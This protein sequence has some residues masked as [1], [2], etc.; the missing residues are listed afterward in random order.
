MLRDNF[1]VKFIVGVVSRNHGR[2]PVSHA[3]LR[4]LF[5]IRLAA[6][7]LDLAE[8]GFVLR[9]GMPLPFK[10]G[11]ECRFRGKVV[12]GFANIEGGV[13]GLLHQLRQGLHALR[14]RQPGRATPRTVFV[15]PKAKL[16]RSHN[17]R[18]TT[19]RAN[20]SRN[21]GPFEKR[22]FSCQLV[23]Y[24]RLPLVGLVAIAPNP[25]RGV[26]LNNPQD[27]RLVCSRREKRA[28]DQRNAR[29]KESA[30]IQFH[31]SKTIRDLTLRNN[32]RISSRIIQI[33]TSYALN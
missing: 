12:V 5:G 30:Y 31:A 32:A 14:Q 24:R 7:Q 9:Q 4:P 16:I 19:G 11:I 29:P 13:T 22:A 33:P 2:G 20:R 15:G 1:A 17:K 23:N 28:D 8:E 26:F 27:V 21:V 3:I 18:R 10:L 25:R 6:L